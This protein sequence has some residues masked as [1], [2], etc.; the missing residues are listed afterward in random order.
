MKNYPGRLTWR[1]VGALAF[2]L[3]GV[4]TWAPGPAFSAWTIGKPIVTYFAG[5]GMPTNPPDPQD[6]A[7]ATQLAEGGYNLVWAST[8][9]EL[10]VAQAHGLR[11]MWLGSKTDY[12]VQTIRNHPALY[13]YYVADE[14]YTNEQIDDIASEVSHLRT[15]DPNHLMYVNLSPNFYGMADMTSYPQYLDYYIS[16]VN[17]TLLSYD[18]YQFMAGGDMAGYFKHLAMISHKAE[19]AGIPFLNVVQTCTWNPG[20]RVPNGNE[21]RYLYNTSLA[22]GAEGVSGY[23]YHR[24]AHTGGMR[25]DDGTTTPL[26]DTAMT[27]NPEFEAIGQQLQSMHRIGTYHLGDLPPGFETTDGSSPMRLPGDSP[28]N[29]SPGIPD[30][31]FAYTPLPNHPN[32]PVKGAVLG[33]FGP[34]GGVLADATSTMV[35]NLDYSNA[36]ETRVNGPGNLS[37]FDT[38]TGTWIAQG[39]AWADVSLLPGGGVLVGLTSAVP[40]PSALMLLSIGLIGLLCYVW[41]KRPVFLKIQPTHRYL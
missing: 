34:D 8:L 2:T 10:D 25:L 39:H 12:T 3:L 7:S 19:E 21:L 14:P 27:V 15:L 35:V 32:P 6:D 30:T 29:L 23:V 26:Y 18:Y 33:L 36:L 41:W 17:P 20:W 13:S 24:Y 38:E 37:V 9:G 22:Y 31:F 28:F 4:L 11:A 16:T 40:E 5:P 1:A